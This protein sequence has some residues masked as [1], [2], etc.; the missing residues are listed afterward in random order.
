M[1]QYKEILALKLTGFDKSVKI[2]Y[3]K[4]GQPKILYQGYDKKNRLYFPRYGVNNL[5]E[6]SKTYTNVLTLLYNIQP[7]SL[8]A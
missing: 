6:N 3:Q 1:K 4:T 5:I 8:T 7:S 2:F